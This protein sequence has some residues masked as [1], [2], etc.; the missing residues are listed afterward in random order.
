MIHP[1]ILRNET[2]SILEGP[3]LQSILIFVLPL[4]LTNLLQVFYSAA[5]M[6]IVGLSDVPGAIGSIGTTTALINLFVNLFAG[7]AVGTTVVVARNIGAEDRLATEASVHSSVLISLIAGT[8][9]GVLGILFAETI[10]ASLGDQGH[11]LE[12]ASLY[13]RIYLAGAPLLS[14]SNTLIA[15]FRAKGDTK[16]PL[17]VLSACGFVN[18]LLNLFFVLVLHMSVDGVAVATVISNLLSSILLLLKLSVLDDWCR[19][20]Y[21]KLKLDGAACRD[22]ILQGVPAS[23]QGIVF[24]LS[25]M[26]IQSTIIGL[27]NTICPGGS[28]IIDGN[29]AAHS[30][31]S[32]AYTAVNSVYQASV[33]FVSQHYGA[34]KYRR[35]GRVMLNCYLVACSIGL[36]SSLIILLMQDQILS[37]YI[38]APLALQTARTRFDIM[39]APYIV[40]GIM[41]VGSGVLRGMGRSLASTLISLTGSCLFRVLWIFFLFPLHPTLEFVYISYPI[42][43]TLTGLCHLTVAMITRRNLIRQQDAGVAESN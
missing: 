30:V 31:E 21:K 36:V 32:F 1:G 37:L 26:L 13:T 39:V 19:F 40:V 38:S 7:F 41:E 14:L 28:D 6:I 29:A 42:T 8:A 10:L 20:D 3:L 11:I 34:E 9:C 16:T 25:N 33:T 35:I 24:S 12:L 43:W 18:V 23:L 5:D 22:I 17:I 4:M 27:N 15:V 2:N